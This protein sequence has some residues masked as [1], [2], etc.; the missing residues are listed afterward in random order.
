M[1]K[2]YTISEEL[3]SLEFPG[4]RYKKEKGVTIES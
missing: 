3:F 1:E 4:P 2:E